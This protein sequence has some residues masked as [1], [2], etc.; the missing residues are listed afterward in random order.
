MSVVAVTKDM[1]PAILDALG[2]TDEDMTIMRAC[3]SKVCPRNKTTKD[4]RVSCILPWIGGNKD[5]N[6]SI[7]W[8]GACIL[9]RLSRLVDGLSNQEL[10]IDTDY[11]ESINCVGEL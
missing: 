11:L 1:V 10:Y 4:C 7:Y 3:I 6:G 5:A 9:Y 8:D 2:N